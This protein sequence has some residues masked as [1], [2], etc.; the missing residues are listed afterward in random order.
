MENR[1][2]LW[3]EVNGHRIAYYTQE[4]PC[5]GRKATIDA[6]SPGNQRAWI[7]ITDDHGILH[8]IPVFLELLKPISKR[9]IYWASR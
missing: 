4:I 2:P 1:D 3:Y 9:K 8:D 7:K 6:I 5:F